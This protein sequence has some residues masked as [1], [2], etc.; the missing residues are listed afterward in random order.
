MFEKAD[1][2]L[3]EISSEILLFV[4]EM[5]QEHENNFKI[6]ADTNKIKV[7]DIPILTFHPLMK[8]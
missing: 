5:C 6:Y 1:K 2:E 3:F 8:C 4:N 7:F